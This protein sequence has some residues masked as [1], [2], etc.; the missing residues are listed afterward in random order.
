VD[1]RKKVSHC[2]LV[3]KRSVTFVN[4]EVGSDTI[5][6]INGREGNPCV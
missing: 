2:N 4:A 5:V 3:G 1:V 6:W